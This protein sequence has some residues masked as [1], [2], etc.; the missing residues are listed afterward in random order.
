MLAASHLL[1]TDPTRFE[2]LHIFRN[3]ALG[4]E[5]LMQ[6]AFFCKQ[7]G[8][9]IAIYVPRE[10]R[11]PMYVELGVVTVGVVKDLVFRSKLEL[12]RSELANRW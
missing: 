2:L 1:V 6:S 3:T 10:S 12:I 4:R 7:M 5:T 9:P 11:F 8:I